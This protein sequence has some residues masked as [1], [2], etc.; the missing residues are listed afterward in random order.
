MEVNI[1]SNYNKLNQS[2]E[3]RKL[4]C[5][6]SDPNPINFFFNLMKLR[7]RQTMNLTNSMIHSEMMWNLKR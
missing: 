6:T 4:L 7:E 2:K 3:H 1:R 5:F